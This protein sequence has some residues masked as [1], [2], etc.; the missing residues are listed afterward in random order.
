MIVKRAN[1]KNNLNVTCC[2]EDN[3]NVVKQ[4]MPTGDSILVMVSLAASW[5]IWRVVWY[6][7]C[8][9]D[10]TGAFVDYVKG[11]ASELF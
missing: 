6:F 11:A 1:N 8:L 3:G 2:V 5:T 10:D 4:R 9:Y 7:W